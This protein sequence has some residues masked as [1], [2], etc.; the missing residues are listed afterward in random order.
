MPVLD[1]NEHSSLT[2]LWLGVWF[3]WEVADLRSR[4]IEVTRP[5]GLQNHYMRDIV[6]P[7][8]AKRMQISDIILY[9]NVEL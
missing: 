3:R 8:N 1:R 4:E 5:Q 2:D 6:T 9:Y 7:G